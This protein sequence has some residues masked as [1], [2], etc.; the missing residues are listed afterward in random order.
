MMIALVSTTL[1]AGCILLWFWRRS[2]VYKVDGDGIYLWSGRF[3]PW[4]EV[5]SVVTRKG[6][7]NIEQ[8]VL[9]LDVVLERGRGMVLPNWL[10]NGTQV[11]E[12]VRAGMRDAMPPERKVRV[13]YVQRRQ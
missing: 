3:V 6:Y 10:E 11:I 2:F 9:R 12:A 7:A 13:Q 8:P 4:T 1:G 5:R